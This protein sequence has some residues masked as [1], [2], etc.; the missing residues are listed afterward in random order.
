MVRN[1]FTRS[2]NCEASRRNLDWERRRLRSASPAFVFQCWEYETQC[3]ENESHLNG[4]GVNES[5]AFSSPALLPFFSLWRS[6]VSPQICT[7]ASSQG[8]R[9]PSL[10]TCSLLSQV[11]LRPLSHSQLIGSFLSWKHQSSRCDPSDLKAQQKM[12]NVGRASKTRSSRQCEHLLKPHQHLADL[13]F[14]FYTKRRQRT[15]SAAH[16]AC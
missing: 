10:L 16:S 11:Q 14:T 3:W 8:L 4:R 2:E 1:L 12:S 9:P 6:S 15:V 13:T 5:T 7:R